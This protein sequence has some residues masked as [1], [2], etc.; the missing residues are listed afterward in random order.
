MK[1]VDISKKQKF[2]RGN[3]VEVLT[4]HQIWSSKDGVQDISPEDV[5][6]KAII[7]YSYAE[8]FG[9]SNVD[10]Y[11]II[12]Q[13]TGYSLAWKR[14]NELKL[15]DEGGEYLFDE[16][17]QNRE[18][19]SKQN[20]DINYILSVLDE[21][22]LSNESVLLLFDLLG[23]RT[24]FITNGEYYV[25]YSDWMVFHPLFVHIKY[26]KT[27]EEAQSGF[28]VKGLEKYNIQKVYD[29]FHNVVARVDYSKKENQIGA[30]IVQKKKHA[31]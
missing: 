8:K 6:R 27:I 14:T 1:D 31:I 12:W 24:S 26:A 3:L 28:T 15:I 29:A 5:G 7:E 18:R 30:D 11:S 20:T 16:A 23:H 21:G 17:N 22:S 19:I 10:D 4:G 13:D 2:K 9:G 25:L